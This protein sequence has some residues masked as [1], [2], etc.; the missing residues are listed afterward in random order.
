MSAPLSPESIEIL[1]ALTL[2][3][4]LRAIDRRWCFVDS[5]EE[6]GGDAPPSAVAEL[7]AAGFVRPYADRLAITE[8]GAA[9]L[10]A[11]TEAGW[12]GVISCLTPTAKKADS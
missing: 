10:R 12:A 8:S 1:R 5:W 3:L 9:A 7:L 2:G 6:E 11:A 4:K